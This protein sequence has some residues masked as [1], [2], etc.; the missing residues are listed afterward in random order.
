M[1]AF[2]WNA[3]P[4]VDV[5]DGVCLLPYDVLPEP[6]V[7]IFLTRTGYLSNFV[8]GSEQKCGFSSRVPKPSQQATKEGWGGWEVVG[9]IMG[10]GSDDGGGVGRRRRRQWP[11]GGGGGGGGGRRGVDGGEGCG[12][13]VTDAQHKANRDWLISAILS[14]ALRLIKGGGSA[15]RLQ[16]AA[17][18]FL[19]ANGGDK[20]VLQLRHKLIRGDEGEGGEGGEV[21][22]RAALCDH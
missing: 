2:C 15:E 20:Q 7:P 12:V 16:G 10:G 6:S 4:S 11:G 18:V 21:A 9:G 17:C 1:P 3:A 22:G 14:G 5:G 19:S 13:P 8:S